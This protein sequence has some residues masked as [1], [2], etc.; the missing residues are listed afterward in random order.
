MISSRNVTI[1][2]TILSTTCLL[3]MVTVL[4]LTMLKIQRANTFMLDKVQQCRMDSS[5]LWKQVAAGEVRMKRQNYA[6]EGAKGTINGGKCCSCQQGPPGPPGGSG[7]SGMDGE[8]GM[9]GSNGRNGRSGKYVM[10]PKNDDLSCQKCPSAVQ[11]PPGHP[12]AKGAR[13]QAGQAGTDGSNGNPSRQGPPGPPG[14]RGQPG[15]IGIQGPPGDPGRVL[16]GAPQGPSGPLGQMGPRGK[17][18]V[19]G[20]DGNS[21]GLGPAGSR[22]EQGQRGSSGQRGLPGP[23]GPLGSPGIK[24]SCNHCAKSDRKQETAAK[25]QTSEDYGSNNNQQNIYNQEQTASGYEYEAR[26]ESRNNQRYDAQESK[27]SYENQ[28]PKSY[29]QAKVTA[30]TYESEAP[31]Q[32]E[33]YGNQGKGIIYKISYDNSVPSAFPN[34]ATNPSKGYNAKAMAAPTNHF[35]SGQVNSRGYGQPN[36]V[37]TNFANEP[38]AF[39]I[40]QPMSS[41]RVYGQAVFQGQHYRGQMISNQRTASDYG[42]GAVGYQPPQPNPGYQGYTSPQQNWNRNPG[43]TQFCEKEQSF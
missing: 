31:S 33:E 11:G 21:G 20:I 26:E 36:R 32:G 4:P 3:L 43:E 25:Q 2:T 18:G 17:P 5:D 19:N 12:G 41:P 13:G 1:L 39:S 27:E 24:G 6:N 14:V 9:I 38:P 35:F 7:Q 28:R 30:S 8:P 16:N 37:A 10:P 22:G 40:L 29:N 15:M 23:T 34:P 42:Y